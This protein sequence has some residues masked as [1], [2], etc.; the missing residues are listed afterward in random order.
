MKNLITILLLSLLLI[1]CRKPENFGFYQPITL[2]M[3]VPDGPAE[4]QTGWYRGCRTGLSLKAFSNS[5][6]YLAPNHGPDI[7]NGV[8]QH[9]PI[10]QSAW[11][12]GFN[13]CVSHVAQFV[14]VNFRAMAHGPLE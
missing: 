11:G 4:F 2:S 3:K 9:D 13:A 12:Q 5:S 14:D 8:F 1:S 6:V 10:F 7:G